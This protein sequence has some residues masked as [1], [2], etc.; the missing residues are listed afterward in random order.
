MSTILLSIPVTILISNND[1]HSDHE[2]DHDNACSTINR[3][4]FTTNKKLIQRRVM[5]HTAIMTMAIG[6]LTS[7]AIQLKRRLG[8]APWCWG[9]WR[10]PPL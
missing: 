10:L 8:A 9:C 5:L 7:I 2:H 6:R 1:H 3:N 4:M